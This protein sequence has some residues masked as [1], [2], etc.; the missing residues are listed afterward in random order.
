MILEGSEDSELEKSL[1]EKYADYD[2]E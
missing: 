1:K 2:I